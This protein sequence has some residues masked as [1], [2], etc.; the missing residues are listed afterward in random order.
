MATG[1]NAIATEREAATKLYYTGTD[2]TDNKC[3]TR[4]KVV[5]MGS[6]QTTPLGGYADNQLVKYTDIQPQLT[7][8]AFDNAYINVYCALNLSSSV[9]NSYPE[10]SIYIT[11]DGIFK[12]NG[13]NYTASAELRWDNGSSATWNAGTS[14]TSG[15]VT[16][17]FSNKG[18]ASWP[19]KG[20]A[21]TGTLIV[22]ATIWSNYAGSSSCTAGSSSNN[23]IIIATMNGY[24]NTSSTFSGITS[25]FSFYNPNSQSRSHTVNADKDSVNYNLIV[26]N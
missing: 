20:T 15:S 11:I 12:F 7:Y 21:P 3:V 9:I 14:R 5:S 22:S 25:S 24:T 2:I 17:Q 4:S 19:I 26:V 16:L 23:K 10:S 18:T 6:Y 13:T 1:T 8:S